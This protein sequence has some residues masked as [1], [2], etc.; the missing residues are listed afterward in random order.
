M[1]EPEKIRSR[2]EELATT[3]D[4]NL[5][6]LAKF[7]DRFETIDIDPFELV[8]GGVIES[9]DLSENTVQGYQRTY[10]Q[11]K[12]FMATQ[13]RH[14][15]CPNEEHVEG[16]VRF[17]M[18]VH[19]NHPNTVKNKLWRLSAAF[20]YWGIDP[21]FP[22]TKEYNPVDVAW[23]KVDLHLPEKKQPPHISI[24]ELGNVLSG[25]TDIRERAVIASQ[26][27]LGLRATELCNLEMADISIDGDELETHYPKFGTRDIL[28]GRTNAIYIASRHERKGNKSFR[29]RLL[30]LDHELRRILERW[31]LIR[32]S[33]GAPSVFLS[34]HRTQLE[35][36]A[37]NRIW[38]K[39]FRPQY[40]ETVRH[41]AVTSHYGRHRFTTYWRVEQ[42]VNRERIKYM[43]GDKAGNQWSSDRAVIDEYIHSY[44]EDVESL[45]RNRIFKLGL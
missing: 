21:A 26:L 8:I 20:D 27:K 18:D 10:R 25:I 5:D 28:D 13:N 3:F 2:R 37:V 23:E 17:L 1:N 4:L 15:V 44:Y 29:P 32:P 38:K 40:D 42:D 16:F 24:H 33:T 36:S 31:L 7:S 34:E 11:W 19:D 45:Y 12:T 14:P 39:Y 35:K 30:P 41:R 43:R 9:R 6:P 22:H